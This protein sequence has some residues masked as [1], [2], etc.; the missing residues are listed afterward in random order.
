MTEQKLVEKV[1]SLIGDYNISY[2][3]IHECS[4]QTSDYKLCVQN[5][6]GVANAESS[7][8]KAGMKPS[9]N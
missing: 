3:I 9:N 4:T 6:L 8:F 7:M 1:N 2:A 5:V